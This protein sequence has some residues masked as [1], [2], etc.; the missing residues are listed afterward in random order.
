MNKTMLLSILLITHD[1]GI[2]AEICDTVAIMNAGKIVEQASVQEIFNNPKHPYTIKLLEAMP[3]LG[4]KRVNL[5][6]TR[7]IPNVVIESKS[8]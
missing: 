5:T 2:V 6:E 7:V 4:K 8:F 3:R 1:L